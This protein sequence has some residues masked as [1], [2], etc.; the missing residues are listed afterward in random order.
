MRAANVKAE[1]I[2]VGI[3]TFD[4]QYT[5]H[6]MTLINATNITIEIHKYACQL[7]EQLWDG[8]AIRHLGIH[9]SRLKDNIDMRKL[10]MFDTTDYEKLE[11]MDATV[12]TIRRRY[13]ND[14]VKRAAFVGNKIDH[15]SG[16]ISREKRSVD[17]K[18]M[19]IE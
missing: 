19:K 4:L 10:D 18:K 2:A 1:V 13:G 3:K 11:M 9:T 16:G 12:D 5:S 8:T 7:F 6:Q 17:Y 14:A 15:M